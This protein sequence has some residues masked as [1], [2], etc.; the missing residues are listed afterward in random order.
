MQKMIVID[1]EQC[2][3]CGACEL[4]CSFKHNAEFNPTKSR[5]HQTTFL[6]QSM[7]VPVVCYQCRKPWCAESCPEEAITVEKDPKGN[8]ALVVVNQDECVGCGVCVPA[9]PF[10]CI[11]LSEDDVAEKCEL[12]D[13]DPEC[14]R[15]CRTG[16]IRFDTPYGG[17][18]AKKKNVAER[19]LS[20][21]QEG[22]A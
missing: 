15:V 2:T 16:A 17:V 12:C 21:Y 22:R 5:I 20:S 18:M 10:G 7:A 4:A 3:G 8:V 1:I 9:C 19:L 6:L 13:G 14:V 11:V